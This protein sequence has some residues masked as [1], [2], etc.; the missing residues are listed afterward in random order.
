MTRNT[1][2]EVRG[3]ALFPDEETALR[4]LLT[5][6]GLDSW[7]IWAFMRMFARRDYETR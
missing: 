1:K 7:Q 5:D 6:G 3:S 4:D 2:I